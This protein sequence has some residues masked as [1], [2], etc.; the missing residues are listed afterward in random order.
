MAD[1]I[2]DAYHHE[3]ELTD[4]QQACLKYSGNRTLMVKGIAGA[5][6]SLVLMERAR[7]LLANYGNDIKN[8]V[9]IFTYQNTLVSTTR[10]FLKI[11]GTN[12]DGALVT[13]INSHINKIY[14][15]L[16]KFGAAPRL[17]YPSNNKS[18]V[19]QRI[20]IIKQA[21]RLH[22]TRYGDH[23][24]HNIDLEFWLEEFDWMK[25]MNIWSNDLDTYLQLPRTGR[26]SKVRMN[27]SDRVVAY[28]LFLCYCEILKNKKQG[29]WSDQTL[30]LI[31]HRD[32]VPENMKYEHI[33]VD[34][35]QDLSL[36]QM[37][38]MMM[39][40]KK[41]MLIAM[42]MNQRIF[43]KHWIPK[44]LG[45]ET[46]TKKLTKSM[47]TTRQI[48]ALAESIR[49]KNDKILSEDDKSLH[50]IPERSGDRL[51]DLVHLENPAEERKYVVNLVKEYL[52]S[53]E[54]ITI[55]II[56]AKN[57]QI[58]IY[59]DW[60]ATENINHELVRKDS[61]F[62]IAK[63]GVKIASAYGAKGLEFDIVI[64]PMFHEGNFPYSF[65]A[66]DEESYEQFIIQMRNLV[67]V[68]MTRARY[69]LIITF[70]GN[71]CSRFFGEMTP[72]L[73]TLTG[74][75]PVIKEIKFI[76]KNKS[77]NITSGSENN[78]KTIQN[79]NANAIVQKPT[80]NDAGLNKKNAV[81]GDQKSNMSELVSF[82]YEKGIEVI[83]NRAKG[84][85]LWAVGGAN[86]NTI[87]KETQDRFGALW[88][89]KAGGSIPTKHRPAW[90]TK[91]KK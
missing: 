62:S 68:S 40:C 70:T 1:K 20:S 45:I 44:Q 80:D 38:A 89:Y 74:N 24:F 79:H 9:A 66:E 63:P 41:D 50:A 87:L 84:G 85:S 2:Y 31:R 37:K 82:L 48:D 47:R 16:A 55:G 17:N 58:P 86:L 7:R 67:Y 90:Q 56:A 19:D 6:K 42:D 12:E 34:E 28:N 49:C 36:A 78:K 23:R 25:D 8:K 91:C 33:L 65:Q 76:P 10:E 18:G 75:K 69:H 52:K 21:I 46:T 26:G 73:Y 13:T 83:D 22:K 57:N 5:G 88:I 27:D 32:Y 4:E 64:I 54:K 30:F 3:I 61:T 14:D 77:V 72:E 51:P 11:N 53:N 60:F 29:D 35:A 43:K 15:M 71:K 39:L 59:S 81:N